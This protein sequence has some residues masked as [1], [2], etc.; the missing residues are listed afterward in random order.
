MQI[1]RVT[2]FV[3]HA[4][5]QRAVHVRNAWSGFGHATHVMVSAPAEL[6][7]RTPFSTTT[8]PVHRAMK[9]LVHDQVYAQHQIS[10][11]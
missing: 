9:T 4:T 10:E 11:A 3:N 5:D 7:S 1:T 8:V 2:P 6:P